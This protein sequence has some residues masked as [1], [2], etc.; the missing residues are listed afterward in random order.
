MLYHDLGFNVLLP[1]QR[2]HGQSQGRVITFGVKESRDMLGW[3]KMHNSVFGANPIILSGLSMGAS[4]MMYLADKELPANVKGIIVDCGFTSPAAIISAVFKRVTHLPAAPVIWVTDICARLFGRF[5]LYDCDSRK[6]LAHNK[7]PII[8]V[9]GKEDNF[10]PCYM[11]QQGY[12]CCTGE[13]KLLLAEGAGHG[14]SFLYATQEYIQMVKQ[15]I[16]D[17]IE[18]C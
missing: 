2:S 17:H 1:Q 3:I 14:L 13:K 15:F 10:V 7:L 8:M 16:K 11:T 5:S 6:T 9:H 18:E 4:T 12:D